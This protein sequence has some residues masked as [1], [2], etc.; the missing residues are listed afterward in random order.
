HNDFLSLAAPATG[1]GSAGVSVTSDTAIPRPASTI[2]AI[3]ASY[4]GAA[5]DTT[6]NNESGYQNVAHFSNGV[7][8]TVENTYISNVGGAGKSA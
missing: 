2:V 5:S 4:Y 3:D 7:D 8:A 1:G 6:L